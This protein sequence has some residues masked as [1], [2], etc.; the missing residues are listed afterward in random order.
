MQE[1]FA[2]LHIHIG[3]AGNGK[4]VKIT[5]SKKLNFANIAYESMDRKGLDMVGIV[6]CASPP[7]IKDIEELITNGVMKQLPAGGIK[8]K[9]KLVIIPGVEVE[10]REENGQAHYLAFF[11]DLKSIKEYSTILDQYITNITLSSQQ[12]GLTG[13]EIFRIV[14]SLHPFIGGNMRIVEVKTKNIF[15]IIKL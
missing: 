2:D 1:F 3:S 8:Y 15:L 6:D 4:P 11:P 7:V 12:T 9:N 5:A 13:A 10:S 14:N